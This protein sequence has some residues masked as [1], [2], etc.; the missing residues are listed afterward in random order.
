MG[1]VFFSDCYDKNFDPVR[2]SRTSLNLSKRLLSEQAGAAQLL[3]E[4][5][6]R[7]QPLDLLLVGPEDIPGF[8]I[9]DLQGYIVKDKVF[10]LGPLADARNSAPQQQL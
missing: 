2:V 9:Y 6:L 3:P 10:S 1:S 7:R 4:H 5:A 8:N